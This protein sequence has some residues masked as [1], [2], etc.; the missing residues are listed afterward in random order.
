MTKRV[1]R[2]RV[3]PDRPVEVTAPTGER[4]DDAI[5]LRFVA[6]DAPGARRGRFKLHGPVTV[7]LPT[8][9]RRL[10]RAE[11]AIAVLSEAHDA[12]EGSEQQRALLEQAMLTAKVGKVSERMARGDRRGRPKGTNGPRIDDSAALAVMLEIAGL[13]GEVRPFTLARLAVES[14]EVVLNG[15]SKASVVARLANRYRT[16]PTEIIS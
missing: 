16:M 6:H 15:V 5:D 11:D 8:G 9:E 10:L 7:I 4:P 13:T 1:V 12:S 3:K 2:G 14:G